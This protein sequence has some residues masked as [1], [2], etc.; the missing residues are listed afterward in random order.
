MH[1]P[2]HAADM[3]IKAVA[4]NIHHTC[5]HTNKHTHTTYKQQNAEF[6]PEVL[7]NIGSSDTLA[8]LMCVVRVACAAFSLGVLLACRVNTDLLRLAFR[9]PGTFSGTS[10]L[11]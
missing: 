2:A 11:S 4:C 7:K 8:C 1:T 9:Q 5:T 3:Q 10:V 6:Q